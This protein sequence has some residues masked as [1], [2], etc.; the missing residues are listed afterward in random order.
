MNELRSCFC[1]SQLRLV[2][3]GGHVWAGKPV[4]S[5]NYADELARSS[6]RSAIRSELLRRIKFSK[7]RPRWPIPQ[8]DF[9]FR[10]VGES[11]P[12]RRR[13]RE[14]G[15]NG[16]ISK[17]LRILAVRLRFRTRFAGDLTSRLQATCSSVKER[18]VR[19]REARSLSA[20]LSVFRF[21][22]IPDS[23]TTLRSLSEDGPG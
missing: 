10:S 5:G 22:H 19:R 15:P 13:S 7:Y 3:N 11:N 20:W 16:R 4:N 6:I 21:Q 17:T 9:I 2:L 1:S 8:G 18:L 12:R 23:W 14:I